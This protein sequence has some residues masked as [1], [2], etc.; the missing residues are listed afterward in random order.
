MPEAPPFAP[1]LAITDAEIKIGICEGCK[2]KC[3][4]KRT[5]RE[6]QY[7]SASG[8]YTDT[9]PDTAEAGAYHPNSS[10]PGFK[11][12]P[13]FLFCS[14]L[15]SDFEVEFMFFSLPSKFLSSLF[16]E[17]GTELYLRVTFYLRTTLQP[18]K[19][20]SRS[21]KT[22][23]NLDGRLRIGNQVRAWSLAA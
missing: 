13:D 11:F 5:G 15:G 21:Q 22:G 2:A 23:S 1:P 9:W 8:G 16:S 10:L 4:D 12:K 3:F 7:W 17:I 20:G 14:L 6:R 19:S 18:T